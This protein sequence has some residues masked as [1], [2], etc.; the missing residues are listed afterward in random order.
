MGLTMGLAGRAVVVTG[1]AGGLGAQIAAAVH[2]RGA[3]LVLVDVAAEPLLAL[4]RRLACEAVV[5][6]I[7]ESNGRALVVSACEDLG[8]APDI[9]IN[10]AGTERATEFAQLSPAEI[11][12]ALDVNLLGAMLLTHALLPAMRQQHSGHVITM[13]SM[14]AIKPVPFN[15]VYNTAK[16]GLV[17]FSLSL[18]KELE[19][20][21]VDATVICP[22]AVSQVGMWARASPGLSGNRLVDSSTVPP[23]A[24]VDGVLRA[25]ARRPRRVL[26]GSR[27]V[28]AGALLSGLST[29]V[30]TA[31]DRLSGIQDVYRERIRTDRGNAL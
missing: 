13:A 24:V 21:G 23:A 30:D 4:Q 31:T 15:A 9:L 6:D 2:R 29:S 20:S 14:A 11:R 10:N 17:A 27:L 1:A 16:A 3:R 5:A 28:R 22:S 19:G 7:A 25:I 8:R 18:S 12:H 26:V